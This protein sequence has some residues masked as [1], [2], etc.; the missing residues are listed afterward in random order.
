MGIYQVYGDILALYFDEAKSSKKDMFN[1]HEE[2][3]KLLTLRS[4]NC[5]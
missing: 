4:L 5:R 1:Y 2:F 3:Q